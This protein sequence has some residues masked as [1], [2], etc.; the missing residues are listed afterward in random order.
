MVTYA[1][2]LFPMRTV[3]LDFHTGP[4]VPDVGSQF[5]GDAFAKVFRDAHVD[6]VTVFAKCH[7]GLLYYE[8]ARAERHPGLVREL[9][10]L[11]EQIEALH[12]AGIRAP[13]YMSVQCDE[14]AATH[15]P[16][17]VA[18]DADG[19]QV[20]AHGA[21][22]LDAAWQILDMSSPYQEYFAEQVREVL[23]RFGPVD[24][25]FLDMCWDQESV[26]QYAQA[27][28]R[29]TALDPASGEDRS[30]Y[31]REVAHRYMER[32]SKMVEPAL[33]AGSPMG[34]WF[35]SR[36]KAGLVNEQQFVRHVEVEALATGGW[37]YSYLP[38]V[39]PLVRALEVP[40]LSH[41][42]RF[43]RSWGDMASLKPLPAL[44]YE[45]CR[46]LMHGLT[47]GVG[48]L[49]PPTGMPRR[50]VYERIGEVYEYIERCEPFVAG[51]RHLSEIAL[52]VDPQ[53][54]DDPGP[55]V[56][57]ALRGLQ[58]ARAQFDVVPLDA[59][60]DGYRAVVI[61][62]STPVDTLLLD[63]VVRYS[64]AG[65]SLILGASLWPRERWAE[66]E[67]FGV[68]VEDVWPY[69]TVFL[70]LANSHLL[71]ASSDL[72]IR[73][74][75]TGLMARP[76]GDG[77][78]LVDVV[79]PYFDR[80]YDHFSGHSYTPPAASSGYAS[81]LLDHNSVVFTVALL[82]GMWVEANEEYQQIF[83]ACLERLV[84]KP[85]LR[86]G[87]PAHLESAVVRAEG[88]TVVHLLSF[89]PSRSAEG[90]DL[91]LDPFPLVDVEIALRCDTRPARVTLEPS[92]Q[93]L[94]WEYE[95]GY[96]TA[97]VTVLDGHALVVFE[98]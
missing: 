94:E 62:D 7:H 55:A 18:L 54:G 86:V 26:S 80:T 17:W 95:E 35:N 81:V 93:E 60:L 57:G 97:K 56:L 21:G 12:N 20:R 2:D 9:D 82:A 92:G 28:M 71:S 52:V 41:T 29:A 4:R 73:I 3:H 91:V 83:S 25:M 27:G 96:A 39:A 67:A 38:Y 40:A 50:T 76:I 32:F 5:D 77:E 69:S 61:P 16:D 74:G 79:V 59:A 8:T 98:D 36:P 63:R 1:G 47:N 45:C 88:R 6:S 44:R 15:H 70:G 49:L 89:I 31:A 58:R 84:P 65:G 87:G 90:L 75:G 78:Q 24:G 11:G 30:R 33:H 46:I 34:T 22:P 85:L 72:D 66:L 37:G 14:F 42:G 53:A 19:R 68:G 13:I 23:D 64:R 43:H 48:D 10:L 51:G